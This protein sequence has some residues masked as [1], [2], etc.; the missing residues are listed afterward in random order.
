VHAQAAQ[1]QAAAQIQMQL[2]AQLPT[3]HN[4]PSNYN[5]PALQFEEPVPDHNP[6]PPH[7]QSEDNSAISAEDKTLLNNCRERLMAISMESCELC[8]EE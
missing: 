2:E 8:H 1:E 5:N 6:Q 4:P 3:I 7:I